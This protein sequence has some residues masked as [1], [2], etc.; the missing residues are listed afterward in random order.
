MEVPETRYA[1]RRDGRAVAYQVFGDGKVDLVFCWGFISHLD[2]QWTNSELTR[3]FER[4]ATFC[5]VVVFDK[6]GTGLSDPVDSVQTLEE[7]AHDVETV[8]D[9]VGL[10]RAA[11]FAESEA[12]PTGVLFAGLHPER[13]TSLILYGSVVKGQASASEAAQLGL[14]VDVMERKWREMDAVLND[15]GKG[16]SLE[17]LAPTVSTQ[18]AWRRGFSMFERASV[19][20]SMARGLIDL[21]RQIDV[22]QILDAVRVP[23]LILHRTG[24]WVPVEFGRY[25]H[26]RI[27]GSQY[28]ELEGSDHIFTIGNSR[29][30]V[31]ECQRFLTGTVTP[32]PTDRALLTILFTDIV[33]STALAAGMGD[34]LWRELLEQHLAVVQSLVADAGGRLVKSTGDGVLAVFGA[35]ARAIGCATSLVARVAELGIT[36]RAG[37]HT[38]EC[39]LIG[40]DVGGLAV[41]VAARIAALAAPGEVMVSST[42]KELVIG[43]GIAFSERGRHDLRGV[44]DR[45]QLYAVGGRDLLAPVEPAS[46][47]MTMADRVTVR[48]ARRVPGALRAANRLS[49]RGTG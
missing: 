11:L 46:M 22:T 25:L 36:I 13:T 23:T 30:I 10:E 17:L 9:A 26:R 29:V 37:I 2:L 21:Y 16:R 38:G 43:S 8:M 20:P 6:A 19:S 24:D 44:P 1:T 39:E 48:L 35:P 42:V 41:H 33:D 32:V 5:R 12:G 28:L 47:H 45:W 14:D 27:P 3:F 31:D 7:R 34:G 15:W 18:A 40:D 49:T 4:L